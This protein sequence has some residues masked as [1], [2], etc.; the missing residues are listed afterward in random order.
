MVEEELYMDENAPVQDRTHDAEA[1]IE[2]S[3]KTTDGEAYICPICGRKFDSPQALAGHMRGHKL[4]GEYPSEDTEEEYEEE[5]EDR[6]PLPT[7]EAQLAEKLPLAIGDKSTRLVLKT[8][9]DDPSIIWDSRYLATHIVQ[10]VGGKK[11]NKY[12][13]QWILNSLYQKLNERIRDLSSAYSIYLPTVTEPDWSFIEEGVGVPMVKKEGFRPSRPSR[14]SLRPPTERREESDSAGWPSQRPMTYPLYPQQYPPY[15]PYPQ[16]PAQPQPQ[17]QGSNITE[18]L[19]IK[20]LD[21]VLNENEE[22][23]QKKQEEPMVEVPNPFGEGMMK[24]PASQAPLYLMVKGLQD[25]MKALQEAI[26]KGTNPQEP[27]LPKV[28]LPDGTELP[29]DQ[30]VYYIQVMQE[31]E[32]RALLEERLKTMEQQ[33]QQLYQNLNPE[34]LM[35]AVEELGFQRSGSPTLDLLHKTR[36]DLNKMADR[37]IQLLELQ[38]KRGGGPV[39]PTFGPKY[40]PEER[41]IKLNELKDRLRRG[42]QLAEIENQIVQLAQGMEVAEPPEQTTQ[43]EETENVA[44]VPQ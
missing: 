25:Q 26:T 12:L 19:L 21:K 35:R 31:K 32:K 18:A 1:S 29:A 3:E 6:P 9:E 41:R 22:V 37:L 10:L 44:E 14:P 24:V 5:T 7:P 20:L 30:A 36:Q 16:A 38:M 28:K 11:Y 17:G 4:R 40:T 23:K 27:K 43:Q 2:E 39:L 33:M 34:R 8:L 13:L 15:P 42:E